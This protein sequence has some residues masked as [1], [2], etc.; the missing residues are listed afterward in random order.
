MQEIVGETIGTLS[1]FELSLLI[2]AAYLHDMAVGHARWTDSRSYYHEARSL[3]G[4][5]LRVNWVSDEVGKILASRDAFTE[6]NYQSSRW[7]EIEAHARK[8]LDQLLEDFKDSQYAWLNERIAGRTP[9]RHRRIQWLREEEQSAAERKRLHLCWG[10]VKFPALSRSSF[11][12]LFD[13]FPRPAGGLTLNNRPVCVVPWSIP[14]PA[15]DSD[16][17]SGAIGWN[18]INTPP[19]RV[20]WLGGWHFSMAPIWLR[21]PGTVLQR[22]WL[23]SKFPPQWKELCGAEFR[24]Y[25]GQDKTAIV[26]NCDHVLVKKADAQARG[27]CEKTFRESIDPVPLRDELLSDPSK[28][29]SWLL[30]CLSRDSSAVWEGLPERDPELLTGL[31]GILFPR[32]PSIECWRAMFWIEDPGAQSRLRVITPGHWK[33]VRND[34]GPYLPAAHDDWRIMGADEASGARDRSGK[35]LGKKSPHLQS[36][37]KQP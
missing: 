9:A 3:P 16:S 18:P 26:W 31:L 33:A 30:Q 13:H 22:Q 24:W 19:D 23:E 15:T 5:F 6:A 21:R 32:R 10:E 27:W 11:G 2:M 36:G 14:A 34:I 7:L 35:P 8:M 4:A 20:A 29:A 25:A 37:G 1:E 28:A 12:Y 17:E